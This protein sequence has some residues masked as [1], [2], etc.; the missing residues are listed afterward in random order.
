LRHSMAFWLRILYK[1]IEEVEHIKCR[2]KYTDKDVPTGKHEASL[3]VWVLTRR[4]RQKDCMKMRTVSRWDI[5]CQCT[6]YNRFRQAESHRQAYPPS[7]NQPGS[8]HICLAFFKPP[9][10]SCQKHRNFKLRN[11]PISYP[12]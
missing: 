6:I 8:T 11:D 2:R 5:S 7:F 3:M 10:N 9:R 4:A 1:C 12:L